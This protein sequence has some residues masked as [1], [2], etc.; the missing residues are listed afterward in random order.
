[1]ATYHNW[2]K[3]NRNRRNGSLRKTKADSP[4]SALWK[5]VHILQDEY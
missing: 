5:S 4:S 1:M 2:D 3:L